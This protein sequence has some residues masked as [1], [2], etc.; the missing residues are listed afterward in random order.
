M[1]QKYNRVEQVIGGKYI[2]QG[3]TKPL[4]FR[5]YDENNLLVELDGAKVDV[6]IAN[7][8]T[9]VVNKPGTIDTD[10]DMVT[11]RLL[12]TD[13]TGHGE[14]RI[15]FEVTYSNGQV[16]K[17]PA[18]EWEE[19]TITP[20]LED[21]EEGGVAYVTVQAIKEEFEEQI[22]GFTGNNS[23]LIS[24]M[25]TTRQETENYV[26]QL[27]QTEEDLL[28]RQ[29]AVENQGNDTKRIAGEAYE[30][31]EEALERS[32]N[33]EERSTTAETQSAQAKATSEEAR[34][35]AQSAESKADQSIT[36]ADSI[37]AN[38]GTS[39]TEIVDM[40]LGADGV[41]RATAGTLTREMH[42]QMLVGNQQN[43]TIQQGANIVTADQ[44][45]ALDVSIPGRTLVSLGNS[46]LTAN[47]MYII[48][49]GYGVRFS[50]GTLF[51]GPTK[52]K[53][54]LTERPSLLRYGT[55]DGKVS[56][57]TVENPHMV[58]RGST[59]HLAT[60][61]ENFGIELNT[62]DYVRVS[63]RDN[64]SQYA[65]GNNTVAGAIGQFRITVD[66][67]EE[68][69]RKVGTVKGSTKTEKINNVK[70]VVAGLFVD[71]Y[72]YG[73]GPGGFK[74]MLTRWQ[75]ATNSYQTPI[76]T[77][78][79]SPSYIRS[80]G[81]ST[82]GNYLDSDGKITFVAYTT[83]SDG[84]TSSYLTVDS[85]TFEIELSALADFSAPKV[86]LYEV[87]QAEYDKAFITWDNT[88]I[89]KR[90]PPVIGAQS[91][92][93]FCVTTE[94]ANLLPSFEVMGRH[95]N[96]TITDPYTYVLK[97]TADYQ[98]KSYDMVAMPNTTYTLSAQTT[99]GR[100]VVY[101]HAKDGTYL[102]KA[103]L[104]NDTT[105]F[106]TFTTTPT[107]A[108]FRVTFGNGKGLDLTKESIVKNAMITL[109]KPKTF[110]QR[111][112]DQLKLISTLRS[113]GDTKDVLYKEGDKYKVSRRI[114]VVTLDGNTPW[115]GADTVVRDVT[116]YA[117]YTSV[118]FIPY[119]KGSLVIKPNG[120]VMQSEIWARDAART[121]ADGRLSIG[122]YNSDLGLA[123]DAK[124]SL[125][126]IVNYF[127]ANPHTLIY[128]TD[129]PTIEDAIFEGALS[130]PGTTQ[131]SLTQN[132]NAPIVDATAKY[133][134]SLKGAVQQLQTKVNDM[135]ENDQVLLKLIKSIV[136]QNQL[137]GL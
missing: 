98:D 118:N 52:F 135:D 14:M 27:R 37:I 21:V 58:R 36:R 32:I 96:A 126:Q 8:R 38:A 94:G 64:S 93:D 20:T 99:N 103:Q 3:D 104:V 76:E 23:E 110:E 121:T 114:K 33:S 16:E 2:R 15:E 116:Y 109:G 105:P 62:D 66:V 61:S 136:T 34:T 119:N 115:Q 100:I 113:V 9:V 29:M 88:A 75:P 54:P 41:T 59:D 80:A 48:G 112:I 87:T 72:M 92:N 67:I 84:V 70:N 63:K 47:K 77:T 12:P 106:L 129:A 46:M 65:G 31:S 42:K 56:G 86:P 10:N 40:R 71:A 85:F 73:A 11:F 50:D 107:T 134:S 83:A 90:Y 132:G 30:K 18:K 101:E 68:I 122:L 79:S 1:W 130:I 111:N 4:G 55:L 26:I 6:L 25:E 97:A 89:S 60:P 53:A 57:S 117:P 35:I 108:L 74:T 78:A 39:N 69:E 82:H 128:V 13:L 19:L 95:A 131:L 120:K 133:V 91:A 51:K 17:F 123:D 49:E 81:S 7:D 125:A 124:P 44:A 45:S 102:T 24:E 137:L 43:A 22:N 28:E 5:F 127:T